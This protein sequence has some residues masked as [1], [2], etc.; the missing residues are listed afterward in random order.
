MHPD[1]HRLRR[2]RDFRRIVKGH[3]LLVARLKNSFREGSGEC[4]ASS[5]VPLKK[6]VYTIDAVIEVKNRLPAIRARALSLF[7]RSNRS[8]C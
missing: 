7:I 1:P 6:L 3:K 4:S 5:R 8:R 2:R